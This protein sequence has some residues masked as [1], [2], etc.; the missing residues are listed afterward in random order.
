MTERAPFSG[1]GTSLDA[2]EAIK[3]HMQRQELLVLDALRLVSDAYV[4]K[5]PGYTN[6]YTAEELERVT[7]LAG[8][9]VRPRLRALV[10]KGMVRDSG[11]TRANNSGRKAAVWVAADGDPVPPAPQTHGRITAAIRRERERILRALVRHRMLAY[12]RPTPAILCE[13]F[14]DDVVQAVREGEGRKEA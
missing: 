6:G 10:L 9:T 2:A 1:P 4:Y 7:G 5:R 13:V 12:W 8:N 11:R 14:G 3:P